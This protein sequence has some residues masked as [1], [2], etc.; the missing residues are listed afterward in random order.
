MMRVASLDRWACLGTS[1]LHRASPVAKWLLLGSAILVVIVSHAPAPLFAA[2]GLLALAAATSG[3]PLGPLLLAS[4]MPVPL[5]G[6]F[7]LSR[8][9][10]T[11]PALAVPVTIVA[12][13]MVTALAALLVAAT[14]PYPDLLA[15]LTRVLPPV[16]ADSLVVTY[17]AIFLLL[18]QV[19]ALWLTIRVR[20]GF[21]SR[22]PAGALPW[23]AHGTALSR[24][25]EIAAIG[26]G[27]SLL[28]AA[29]LSGRLYDVMRL[30]GYQGR[31]AP[32]QTLA[33]RREDWRVLLLSGSLL[34]V[35]TIS[36]ARRLLPG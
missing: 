15:P 3:V 23:P 28:R 12:K 27:L 24:R 30:R 36:I 4:L 32:T 16:M 34:A 33:L 6:L 5:V 14:T 18:A 10:G 2:Y 7:A 22:P 31:L 8:W 20:G 9:A 17:R 13:G 1:W 35:A 21:T 11:L 29:D 26:A 19:E 25:L